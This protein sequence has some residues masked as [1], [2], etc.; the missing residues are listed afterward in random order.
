MTS[1][2]MTSTDYDS[3]SYCASPAL[4]IG[5]GTDGDSYCADHLDKSWNGV[6]P[7]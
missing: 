1:P 3:C 5:I 6:T 7:L 2:L 4:Y